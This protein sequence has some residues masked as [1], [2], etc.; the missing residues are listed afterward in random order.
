MIE[1]DARDL[2]EMPSTLSF[3]ETVDLV[4]RA[5]QAAGLSIFFR[6]DHAGAARSMGL[7]MP[8]TV[9]IF[10]GSPRGGT[11]LMLQAPSAALDLP[12]R[13]LVREATSGEVLVAFHPIRRLLERAGVPAEAAARVEPGQN[14]IVEALRAGPKMR[15]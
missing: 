4:E 7:D 8:P 15:S 13:V 5:I 11:P 9:V 14:I 2:V 12:F 6:I 10:Y 3:L 1:V